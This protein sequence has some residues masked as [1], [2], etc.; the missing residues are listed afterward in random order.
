LV[1]FSFLAGRTGRLPGQVLAVAIFALSYQKR[2][3]GDHL[4]RQ[5]DVKG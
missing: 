1:I 3:V 5:Y 4:G 2:D